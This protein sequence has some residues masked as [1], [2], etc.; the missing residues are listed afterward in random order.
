MKTSFRKIK[1]TLLLFLLLCSLT[2]LF[3]QS[4][5][6]AQPET[7]LEEKAATFIT[8]VVGLDLSKYN[9]TIN[10]G[11]SA[12]PTPFNVSSPFIMR[13]I[14]YY[15]TANSSTVNMGFSFENGLLNLCI[16]D[17]I[18]GSPIFAQQALTNNFDYA[19]FFMQ[20]YQS[21]ITNNW[22]SDVSYLQSA[23]NLINTASETNALTLTNDN[24]KF[25]V[26]S[27]YSS[28]KWAYTQ[29][30]IDVSRKRVELDFRNGTLR[31]LYD[32]W[33]LYSIGSTKYISEQQAIS[34]ALVAAKNYTLR[35]TNSSNVSATNYT[36]VGQ[37]ATEI[38]VIPDLTNAITQ[39]RLNMN[40]RNNTSTSL[41]PIWQ[42]S[43]TF[44][45]QIYDVN[46]ITVAVWGDTGQIQ[47]CQANVLLGPQAG[48]ST[49]PTY[50]KL[51]PTVTPSS[52]TS[53]NDM[54]NPKATSNISTNTTNTGLIIEVITTAILVIA[55]VTI[56][57][58]KR[59]K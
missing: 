50:N 43:F 54:S 9:V 42:I 40:V 38:D 3:Q 58:K 41:Y 29:N 36:I 18:Q 11:P 39:T 5:V 59:S 56:I 1:T 20:K 31:S 15:L 26:S 2:V 16:I 21:Y 49:T 55:A 33:N 34:L 24:I 51:N 52:T 10:T 30:G 57:L 19:K 28:F 14:N 4:N 32:G 47:S 23:N 45:S 37:T 35:F 17:Y 48:S 7:T 44:L 25:Q 22:H 27:D 46:G 12:Q 53:L 13:G 8:D 6:Q